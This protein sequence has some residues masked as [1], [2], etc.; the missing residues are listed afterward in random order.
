MSKKCRMVWQKLYSLTYRKRFWNLKRR[1]L[2]GTG[3][4]L[5]S[6]GG[7][8]DLCCAEAIC[9][10]LVNDGDVSVYGLPFVW[11]IRVG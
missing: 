5:C 10:G 9:G 7:R 4:I 11:T 8:V 6:T 3:R 1:S 2:L